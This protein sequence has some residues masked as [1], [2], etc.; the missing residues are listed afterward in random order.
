MSGSSPMHNAE[1]FAAHAELSL[2]VK[3][4]RNCVLVGDG[5]GASRAQVFGKFHF[6][7]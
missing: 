3:P 2:E 4:T 5:D 6:G 7:S 1:L